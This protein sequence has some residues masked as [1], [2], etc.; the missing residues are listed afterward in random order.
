[1]KV[2]ITEDPGTVMEF[3]DPFKIYKDMKQYQ[4]AAGG[5]GIDIVKEGKGVKFQ[6]RSIDNDGLVGLVSIPVI[7]R[8]FEYLMRFLV[9][10]Y[11][12]IKEDKSCTS[13]KD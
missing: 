6:I 7:D 9:G 4:I 12:G 13:E 11:N 5:F 3:F 10:A 8:E 1:M 2:E